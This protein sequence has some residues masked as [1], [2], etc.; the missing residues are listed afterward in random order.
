MEL[1]SDGKQVCTSCGQMIVP[2][3]RMV[4]AEDRPGAFA[5]PWHPTR[6]AKE[7]DDRQNA[8]VPFCGPGGNVFLDGRW[9]DYKAGGHIR[10]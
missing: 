8:A 10:W 2:G 9:A 7:E 1:K 5:H 6:A 3:G 4:P